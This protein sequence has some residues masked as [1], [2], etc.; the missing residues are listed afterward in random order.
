M[1]IEADAFLLFTLLLLIIWTV[2][3]VAALG[4]RLAGDWL[5]GERARRAVIGVPMLVVFAL[6]VIYQWERGPL[7][8][9]A[10]AAMTLI[11]LLVVGYLTGMRHEQEEVAGKVLPQS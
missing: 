11:A 2:G 3:L 10:T 9:W 7:I 1:E 5:R 6:D 4:R 8:V